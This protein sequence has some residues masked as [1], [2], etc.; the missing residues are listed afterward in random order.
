MEAYNVSLGE[1]PL[2]VL[3]ASSTF[4]ETG[5]SAPP[6]RAYTEIKNRD[7][8]IKCLTDKMDKTKWPA[9]FQQTDAEVRAFD[10]VAASDDD[11]QC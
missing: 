10:C 1:L 3:V 4:L 5:R 11:M 6:L 7:S 8:A 2:N 9:D